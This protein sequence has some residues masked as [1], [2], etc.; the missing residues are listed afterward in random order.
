MYK[1]SEDQ[2]K[3]DDGNLTVS[4]GKPH[5]LSQDVSSIITFFNI[6]DLD[7]DSIESKKE[8]IIELIENLNQMLEDI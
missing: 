5:Y 7:L 4:F 3:R 6:R 2:I 1:L 8:A